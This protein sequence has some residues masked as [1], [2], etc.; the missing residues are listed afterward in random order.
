MR[1]TPDVRSADRD[2]LAV[3]AALSVSVRPASPVGASVDHAGE[4]VLRKHLS[5]YVGSGGTVLVAELDGQIAGFLLARTV[6]PQLFAVDPAIVVDAL[7]V[8]PDSRR[9]G[10]G[11]ALV[12]GVA[13]L[14]GESGAPYVYAGAPA[15]D[16]AMQR[17]LARLGF[18]PAA[19][20]R[21]V[22][23]PILLR[24]LAQEGAPSS[25]RGD[26]RPRGRRESTRAA[27]DDIIARRR[28]ARDA[29]LPS[30][31]LDLR[32]FQAGRDPERSAS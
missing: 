6:G 12:A 32:A 8:T 18:A 20:H 14:A 31:P 23:T 5:V 16:R 25:P 1:S 7:F 26:V 22:S 30:G 3:V 10:I 2:D 24:R 17:F 29:G 19:G 13:A 11:H 27:I 21:V 4:D 28:R 15:G 9:R